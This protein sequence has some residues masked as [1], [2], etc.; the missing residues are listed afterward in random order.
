MLSCFCLCL[1]WLARWLAFLLSQ[2]FPWR[3]LCTFFSNFQSRLRSTTSLSVMSLLF[4]LDGLP[5]SSN[6][7]TMEATS[8]LKAVWM[9][10]SCWGCSEVSLARVDGSEFSFWLFQ[11]QQPS[12]FLG[13]SV[14]PTAPPSPQSYSF[15][16]ELD[17]KL[18]MRIFYSFVYHKCFTIELLIN[19]GVLMDE[20]MDACL[21]C[22]LTT[23]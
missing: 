6:V 23:I 8:S 2:I 19:I 4:S 18:W 1:S 5:S 3:S 7:A 13:F 12:I 14:N 20:L 10:P 9:P 17:L 11:I 15:A 21:W 16:H 22:G